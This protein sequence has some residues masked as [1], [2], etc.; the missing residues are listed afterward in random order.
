MTKSQIF[1]RSAVQPHSVNK[2]IINIFG[3][4]CFTYCGLNAS[5]VRSCFSKCLAGPL[6]DISYIVILRMAA[7]IFLA[8]LDYLRAVRTLFVSHIYD[9]ERK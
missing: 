2:L 5:R 1:S 3:C 6:N 4:C 7:L 8:P 9:L